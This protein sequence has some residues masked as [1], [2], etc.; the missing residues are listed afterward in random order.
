MIFRHLISYFQPIFPF[1]KSVKMKLLF[2]VSE[3]LHTF[4]RTYWKCFGA[5]LKM[6]SSWYSFKRR[7]I[8]SKLLKLVALN[9]GTCP[10]CRW[11]PFTPVTGFTRTIS[12]LSHVGVEFCCKCGYYLFILTLISCNWFRGVTYPNSL[13][14]SSILTFIQPFLTSPLHLK[15]Q[16]YSHHRCWRQ[17]EGIQSRREGQHD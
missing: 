16:V 13:I 6:T 14:Y 7:L 4:A 11:Y 2:F 15:T 3:K 5:H 12:S 1:S 8:R 17:A 9:F 10:F